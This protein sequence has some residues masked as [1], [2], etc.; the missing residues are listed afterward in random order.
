MNCL[1]S[2][3]ICK[4]IINFVSSRR[5]SL[6]FIDEKFSYLRYQSSIFFPLQKP[7]CEGFST[8]YF[9]P[10]RLSK[11]TPR[12]NENGIMRVR[13]CTHCMIGWSIA[14]TSHES[15]FQTNLLRKISVHMVNPPEANIYLQC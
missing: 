11:S 4:V 15:F 12:N 7:N 9:N 6:V 3:Q 8:K 13:G 14:A 1:S 5:S 2:I 10:Y